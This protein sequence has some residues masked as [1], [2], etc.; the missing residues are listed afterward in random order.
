MNKVQ[1]QRMTILLA[2][3]VGISIAVGFL[4]YALRSNLNHFYT[5]SEL[6]EGQAYQGQGIRVGGL[7]K[8]GSL[9]RSDENNLAVEFMVTDSSADVLVYF[10]GILPDLFREGQG[11]V[12][13]GRFDQGRV[14]ADEVLA[15]H[16][17]T[18]MPP[19]AMEALEKAGAIKKAEAI[20]NAQ[21]EAG[22]A[23]AAQDYAL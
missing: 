10:E 13:T 3:I 8:D 16:D 18:Y 4:L 12:V 11:I 20:R 5:P 22:A 19:E 6:A 2:A 7:V 1:K 23:S 17:E 15:K 9:K 21:S 14:L